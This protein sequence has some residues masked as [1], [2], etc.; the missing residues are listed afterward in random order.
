MS[1]VGASQ[2]LTSNSTST[3]VTLQ[4][5]RNYIFCSGT[6][7]SG[8]LT[9]QV[10]FDGT[11]YAPLKLS[12]DSYVSSLAFTSAGCV[13]LA[14]PECKLRWVLSGATSPS[15]VVQVSSEPALV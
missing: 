4:K 9:P 5:G 14:L 13:M 7:G 12:Q 15:V 2:T 8:T 1:L 6:F 3:P 11:N 10:S